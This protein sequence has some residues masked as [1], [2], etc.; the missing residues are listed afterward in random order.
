MCEKR[1]ECRLTRQFSIHKDNKEEKVNYIMVVVAKS[2]EFRK[3]YEI[4]PLKF[5]K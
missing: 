5:R 1:E 3:I 2:F 4:Q